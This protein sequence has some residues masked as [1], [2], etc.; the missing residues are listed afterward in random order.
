[1]APVINDKFIHV[2]RQSIKQW[3]IIDWVRVSVLIWDIWLN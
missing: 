1:M 3:H 2:N